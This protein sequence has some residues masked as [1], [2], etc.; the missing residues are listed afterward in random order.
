MSVEAE[1]T[2]R[3]KMVNSLENGR[4]SLRP[5]TELAYE[6]KATFFLNELRKI[7]NEVNYLI[8]KIRSSPSGVDRKQIEQA[9]KFDAIYVDS[10][11]L[12]ADQIANLYGKII[13]SNL[14]F[15]PFIPQLF[16]I[17][18]IV[19]DLQNTYGG[20]MNLMNQANLTVYSIQKRLS[21]DD[22]R[23]MSESLEDLKKIVQENDEV[24]NKLANIIIEQA[25]ELNKNME[26]LKT[27]A[28]KTSA[29]S[30]ILQKWNQISE[31]INSTAK[32]ITNAKTIATTV[33]D[34]ASLLSGIAMPAIPV[35]ATAAK[36]ILGII[37]HFTG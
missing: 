36:A 26:A 19:V 21:K 3:D 6:Y 9:M 25:Q 23:A 15:Q 7:D 33:L 5:L 1:R 18:K 12:I 8:D 4:N 17:R 11:D 24:A 32:T 16:S 13:E 31:T 34:I 28:P 37:G 22:M 2:L 27:S 20:R 14:N 29:I 10:C 30:N 35:V